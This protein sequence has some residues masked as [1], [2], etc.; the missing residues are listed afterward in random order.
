MDLQLVREIL[1]NCGVERSPCSARTNG[2]LSVDLSTKVEGK[3][4]LRASIHQTP[5]PSG[6]VNKH[7]TQ[8]LLLSIASVN[9][10]LKRVRKGKIFRGQPEIISATLFLGLEVHLQLP[11]NE[12]LNRQLDVT[13]IVSMK[14]STKSNTPPSGSPTLTTTRVSST[15]TAFPGRAKA[16]RSWS[17]CEHPQNCSTRENPWPCCALLLCI[18]GNKQMRKGITERS[19]LRSRQICWSAP[20]LRTLDV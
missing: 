19:S 9:I 1:V 7:S 8:I 2:H 6:Q 20:V 4:G 5:S 13:W 3:G 11:K 15:C 17:R 14:R 12:P 10:G 16:M 18:K